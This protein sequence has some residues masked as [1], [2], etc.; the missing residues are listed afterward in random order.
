MEKQ[1]TGSANDEGKNYEQMA[2]TSLQKKD[3]K[4]AETNFLAALK[5]MEDSGDESGQAY[6]LGN[7]GNI[8]FQRRRWEEARDYYE[9]SLTLMEKLKDERGI[10]S[11]L[12]NLGNVSF[13]QGELDAAQENY[14]KALKLVEQNKNLKGQ[15]QYNENLGNIALQKRDFKAAEQYFETLKSFLLSEKEDAEKVAIVEDKIKALKNQ[16]EYLE[17]TEKDTQVEIDQL[18]QDKRHSDLIKKYQ[19]LEDMFYEA[20]RFDKVIEINRKIIG[21]LE[22]MNDTASIAIC[23]ANLGSTLLQEGLNG[24]PELLEQAETNFKQALEFVEKENDQR[25]LAYLLGNLGILYLHKKEF[26]QSYDYYNRS[27]KIMTEMGDELGPP[28]T[29]TWGKS[30]PS[31]RTGTRRRSNMANP[32]RSWKNFRTDRVWL[33]RMRH[34]ERYFCRKKILRRRRNFYKMPTPCTRP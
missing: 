20:K 30:K 33:S 26:D 32:C 11:S 13:Y 29:P 23:H 10:E 24:K 7:L 18:T 15:I 8:Y 34:W 4:E 3:F 19:E 5:H 22:E 1:S 21:V 17:A 16:P 2:Y 31:R 6:T 27:L 25:R 14:V 28:V 9:K 12:G